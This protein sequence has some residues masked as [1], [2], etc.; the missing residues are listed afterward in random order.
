MYNVVYT[1]YNYPRQNKSFNTYAAAKG[2]YNRIVRSPGVRRA[3][4]VIEELA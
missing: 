3:E 4:L 2:F 1:Y